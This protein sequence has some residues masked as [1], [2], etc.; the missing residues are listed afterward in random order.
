MKTLGDFGDVKPTQLKDRQNIH[1]SRPSLTH[2]NNSISIY[3]IVPSDVELWNNP[4]L[5]VQAER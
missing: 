5:Q 1:C 4:I 2:A 3:L